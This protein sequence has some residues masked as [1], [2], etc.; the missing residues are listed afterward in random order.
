[1]AHPVGERCR[2][3]GTAL[4]SRDFDLGLAEMVKAHARGEPSEWFQHT[5]NCNGTDS[6]ATEQ[7]LDTEH[8]EG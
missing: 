8:A 6:G 4:L 7:K 5:H 1:M 3:C 2:Y